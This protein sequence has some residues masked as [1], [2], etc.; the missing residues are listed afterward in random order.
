MN[1]PLTM[2]IGD[3]IYS[4]SRLTDNTPYTMTETMPA[5]VTFH[6]LPMPKINFLKVG[7]L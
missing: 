3:I 1:K 7:F 5:R 4:P 6:K 2:I